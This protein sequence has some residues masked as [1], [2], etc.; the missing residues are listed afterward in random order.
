LIIGT[1]IRI[2]YIS[3][4]PI[5][6]LVF[7]HQTNIITDIDMHLATVLFIG[8]ESGAALHT[9]SDKLF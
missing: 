2:L 9:I 8:L 6:V 5:I 7:R 1:V 4:I 3:I